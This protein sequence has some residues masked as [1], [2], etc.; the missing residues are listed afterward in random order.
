MRPRLQLW[1]NKFFRDEFRR[2]EPLVCSNST[3]GDVDWV[4]IESVDYGRPTLVI[5][6]RMTSR[7]GQI[8]CQSVTID[9]GNDD[10]TVSDIVSL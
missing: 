8:T 2:P 5:D 4:S 10:F 1:P 6:S 7:H 3:S 9:R